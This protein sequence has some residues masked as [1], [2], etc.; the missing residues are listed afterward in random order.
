[1]QFDLVPEQPAVVSEC[2]RYSVSRA[3]FG[4]GDRAYTAWH[5]PDPRGL[6][7]FLRIGRSSRDL[8]Q[9]CREHASKF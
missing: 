8:M 6:A 1:M 5:K 3:E 9:T 2:G 7:E 4:D